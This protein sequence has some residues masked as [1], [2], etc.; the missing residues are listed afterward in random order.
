MHYLALDSGMLLSRGGFG[1]VLSQQMKTRDHIKQVSGPKIQTWD[2]RI[3]AH[4][5][6]KNKKNK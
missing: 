5:Q 2:L 6:L 4:V 1:Q 3:P